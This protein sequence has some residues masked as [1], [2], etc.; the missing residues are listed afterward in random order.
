MTDANRSETE[1]EEA[2]RLAQTHVLAKTS[3][4][5]EARAEISVFAEASHQADLVRARAEARA[6][7]ALER[8]MEVYGLTESDALAQEEIHEIPPDAPQAVA[9]LR[10]ELKA[11]GEV[12]YGAIEA[13]DALA[14]RL[15]HL[16]VQSQ[17]IED[18]L[19]EIMGGI[20]ELDELT[21]ER[22]L[23]TFDQVAAAFREEF[24][25]M[26]GGG[27]GEIRL[28]DPVNILETGLD[29]DVQLP[30][31]RRQPLPL[32]SGGERS[33]CALAFLFALLRV[34]PSPLVVLD[35]VD[36]P[37][38][39]RNVERFAS[40]LVRLSQGLQFF[41]ITHNPVTIEVAQT[42][43]GVT[44]QEPG[45]STLIPARLGTT[46]AQLMVTLT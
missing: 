24:E 34:R 44:M 4:A 19:V 18:A 11:M 40:A 36:A 35:E 7:T 5:R 13:Y 41:V 33:L 12:S 10:R 30:G 9:R 22:F 23:T 28:T 14:D 27:V 2:R 8:L 16:R 32:L 15:A 20:A 31:K 25:T 46:K 17:D 3:E 43:L 29:I 6:A 42:W 26:F 38:D 45:V 37:L 1:A 39:G 21:R